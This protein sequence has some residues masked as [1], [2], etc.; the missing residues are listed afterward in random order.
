MVHCNGIVGL[1]RRAILSHG[2]YGFLG[3]SNIEVSWLLIF[4]NARSLRPRDSK[5]TGTCSSHS[6]RTRW[7]PAGFMPIEFAHFRILKLSRSTIVVGD[8]EFVE[9]VRRVVPVVLGMVRRGDILIPS[10]FVVP[11]SISFGC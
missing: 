5:M 7:A 1:Y 2:D 10:V 4:L 6:H 9:Y 11:V 8:F 3:K